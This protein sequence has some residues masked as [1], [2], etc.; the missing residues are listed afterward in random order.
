M[1]TIQ[2]ALSETPTPLPHSRTGATKPLG[3]FLAWLPVSGRQN[4]PAAQ[5]KRLR[6]LRPPSPPLE[7]LP[8]LLVNNDIHTPG[9]ETSIVACDDDDFDAKTPMPTN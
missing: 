1:Q 6:A 7:H 4:D 2:P 9:H 8:L 3:D 5:R